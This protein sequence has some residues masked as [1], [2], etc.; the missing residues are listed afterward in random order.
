MEILAKE[1]GSEHISQERCRLAAR[2]VEEMFER[3][4]V[5][6]AEGAIIGAGIL[7]VPV[8]TIDDA[9]RREEIV[10]VIVDMIRTG[11]DKLIEARP[12]KSEVN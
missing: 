4:G 1:F 8:S 12:K 5:D 2:L 9:E 3:L 10:K 11:V 7:S 6:Y